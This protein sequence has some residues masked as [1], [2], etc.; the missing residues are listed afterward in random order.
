MIRTTVGQLLIN[1]ALPENMRDYTRVLDKKGLPA[2][3]RQLGEQHPAQYREVAQALSNVGHAAATSTGGYSFGLKALRT[4]VTTRAAVMKLEQQLRSIYADTALSDQ[5]RESAIFQATGDTRKTLSDSVF[6]EALASGNPLAGQVYSGARGNQA[7]LNSLL[8]ADLT[9]VDHKDRAI[10]MPILRNYSQGLRPAEYFAGAFGARKGLVDLK[11]GTADAG[12]LGKQMSQM[13]HRLLVTADDAEDDP[14]NPS[15][16]V[17]GLP[18]D[19]DDPDN[20]GALLATTVGEYSRNTVLT[21]RLLKSLK[22]AGHDTILVR[23]PTVGGPRDGGVYA[24]DVGLREK[25]R[26]PPLGDY[27]GL[28]AAQAL[29]EPVTQASISS[30][31][32]G[33]VAGASAGAISGFKGINA[34]IQSPK[35]FPGGAAHAQIDGRVDAVKPAPQ[36]GFYV[37]VAGQSHYVG[38][39]YPVTVKPGD[40]LEAGDT[41]S[42]GTAVPSEIVKHKGIGEARRYFATSFHKVLKDSGIVAHR[43]NVELLSRG[44]LNHVRLT[45][46]LGDWSPDDVLPYQTLER[47]WQSRVGM[48]QGPPRALANR[49]LEQ[50]VLHYTIGT[51]LRPSVI[52]TLEKHGVKAVQAHPEPPPF[53]PEMIRGMANVAHDQDWMTKLLGS[54]QKDSLLESARRGAV[55]D[56]SGSSYVPALAQ[57]E[58]FGISGL[59]RGWKP[60]K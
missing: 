39:G 58:T 12:Y 35:I 3:F 57:G 9:Y 49:F 34:M 6:A 36:G 18:V 1:Q 42:E 14:D 33:G 24:R 25:G 60:G 2:L 37:S 50:P 45:D 44:L 48:Q 29:S 53:Q 51:K 8:G 54:Y 15:P 30:K 47:D 19:T 13:A 16:P 31:H 21:P 38:A 22:A 59:S 41:I 7:N 23:S 17:R 52:T 43:R 28:A 10:P 56:V 32:S 27:V 4:P 55:S 46:E 40:L 5:G 11:Q 26:L 20:E